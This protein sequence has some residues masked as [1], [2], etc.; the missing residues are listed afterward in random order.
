MS[1][2]Q[3]ERVCLRGVKFDVCRGGDACSQRTAAECT[4]NVGHSRDAAQRNR[5]PLSSSQ[6]WSGF[7]APAKPTRSPT[8]TRER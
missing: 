2:C 1:L 5:G 3:R 8:L 4:P 7:R 6:R